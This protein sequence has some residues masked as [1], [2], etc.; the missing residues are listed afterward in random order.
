MR[1]F[2]VPSA[3]AFWQ[4]PHSFFSSSET[5]QGGVFASGDGAVSVLGFDALDQLGRNPALDGHP[6]PAG[7]MGSPGLDALLRWGLFALTAPEHQPLRRAVA[8]GFGARRIE[9]LLPLLRR[10][11]V[12]HCREAARRGQADLVHDVAAPLA[13][14]AFCALVD[15][16]PLQAGALVAAVEEIGRQLSPDSAPDGTEAAG[17]QA[18]A[19]LE[20]LRALEAAGASPLMRDIAERLPPDTPARPADLVAALVL[21]SIETMTAG[22]ACA[23]DC[24]LRQSGVAEAVAADRYGWPLAVQEAFRLTSPVLLTA[25]MAQADIAWQ[26]DIIRRGTTVMLWW[27]SGNVDP[28]RFERPFTFEPLRP[29]ARHL[30]FGTGSHSCLGRQLAAMLAEELAAA[31]LPK[32]GQRAI[33]IGETVFL[34]RF[35]RLPREAPIRFA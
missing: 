6:F 21:D 31:L 34:Q 13:G 15:L 19:V 4:D 10:A 7:G 8:A 20:M 26:D 9:T 23:L 24:L 11:A 29:Q 32:E 22:L 5:A 3:P 25:R 28:R 1:T 12:E 14:L 33:R 17:Q 30:A 27:P 18:E 2:D 16:E 35:A